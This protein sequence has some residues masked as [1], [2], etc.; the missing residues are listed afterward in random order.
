MVR[1][2]FGTCG[3]PW[4][5][6][7]PTKPENIQD[8]GDP[9]N[10]T[11]SAAPSGSPLALCRV[12]KHIQPTY[13]FDSRR[14][15]FEDVDTPEGGGGTLCKQRTRNEFPH[16]CVLLLPAGS[17]ARWRQGV[18]RQEISFSSERRERQT[19]S[20][21]KVRDA[22]R[23]A[24]YLRKKTPGKKGKKTACSTYTTAP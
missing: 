20:W 10:R 6:S 13:H 21:C 8:A 18:F 12:R 5:E 24:L 11:R 7:H 14:R 4:T 2:S 15:E 9:S 19:G 22:K 17:G 3:A 23:P 1:E 16:V